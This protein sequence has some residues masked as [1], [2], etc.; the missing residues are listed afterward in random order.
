MVEHACTLNGTGNV[1]IV[2]MWFPSEF[3]GTILS[4]VDYYLLEKE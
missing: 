2:S 4:W 1:H 3:A